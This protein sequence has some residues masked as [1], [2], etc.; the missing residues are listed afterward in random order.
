MSDPIPVGVPLTAGAGG[1][2]PFN[3]NDVL[4]WKALICKY[5]C[6]KDIVI[7]RKDDFLRTLI[8]DE[9]PRPGA[10]NKEQVETA[11]YDDSNDFS[12]LVM[13]C[14]ES[15]VKNNLL[16]REGNAEPRVT[17][18]LKSFC[19]DILQYDMLDIEELV[20]AVGEG[21]TEIRND[22]NPT[23]IINMLKL[24]KDGKQIS[25][26]EASHDVKPSTLARLN[27]LGVIII[28][29]SS[30]LS[31]SAIGEKVLSELQRH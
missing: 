18:R 24:L 17:L 27:Q 8:A 7:F 29:F 10:Y 26:R 11:I 22:K 6:K 20:R 12:V 28:S 16:K 15:L 19:R 25:V 9:I 31:I 4:I 23:A 1:P 5:I 21:E 30:H 2:G 13:Y 14:V 3:K